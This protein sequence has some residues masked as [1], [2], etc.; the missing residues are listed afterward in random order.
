[1]AVVGGAEEGE[2]PGAGPDSGGSGLGQELFPTVLIS[3][4]ES[5]SLFTH[6]Q[7]TAAWTCRMNCFAKSQ[8]KVIY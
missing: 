7:N 4:L 1:M 5:F 3:A 8:R 6:T 2:R